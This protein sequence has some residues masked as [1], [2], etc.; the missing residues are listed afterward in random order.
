MRPSIFPYER[1]DYDLVKAITRRDAFIKNAIIVVF[2]FGLGYAIVL[3]WKQ[4]ELH[5]RSA[6]TAFVDCVSEV[7]MHGMSTGALRAN[8]RELCSF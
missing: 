4:W 5:E 8:V 6:K 3:A 2:A 7:A 1:R